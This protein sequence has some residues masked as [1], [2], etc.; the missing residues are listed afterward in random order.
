M[1]MARCSA[2]SRFLPSK[3]ISILA[4]DVEEI[5]I[6]SRFFRNLARYE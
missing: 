3:C 5:T 2:L 6:K 4:E 1:G